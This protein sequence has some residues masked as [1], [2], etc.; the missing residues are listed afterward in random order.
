MLDFVQRGLTRGKNI[1]PFWIIVFFKS[2]EISWGI[3]RCHS[4]ES[5]SSTSGVIAENVDF[6]YNTVFSVKL[7]YNRTFSSIT[8]EVLDVAS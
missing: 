4:Y 7:H 6:G 8:P 3:Q 2:M 1:G 5:K